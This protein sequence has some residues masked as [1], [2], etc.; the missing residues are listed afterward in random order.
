MNAHWRLQEFHTMQD[1][2]VYDFIGVFERFSADLITA[3]S[4]IDEQL[5]QYATTVAEHKT[6]CEA[7]VAEYYADVLAQ[8]IVRRIY[9]ADFARFG[10][11]EDVALCLSP[12][13][14][15]NQ[16][17]HLANPEIAGLRAGGEP[18]GAGSDRMA[19]PVI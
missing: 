9:E 7:L 19:A 12:P 1:E 10:Y 2:I 8:R 17:G 15:K 3:L 6:H 14:R 11:S 16:L 18:I 5:I 13:T 4:S